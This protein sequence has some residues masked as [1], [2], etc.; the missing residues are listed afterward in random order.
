MTI[1]YYIVL[2]FL[3]NTKKVGSQIL[4]NVIKILGLKAILLALGRIASFA[5][6]HQAS[7]PMMFY[8][9]ESMGPTVYDWSTTLMRNMKQWLSDC[10]MGRVWNFGFG[11]TLST[12]F[13]EWVI[14]LIPRVDIAPHVVWDPSQ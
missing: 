1:D 6:L 5:S 4:T 12:F 13:F 3:P 9:V 14:G 10:K 11:N 7:Q 2:Y 8:A